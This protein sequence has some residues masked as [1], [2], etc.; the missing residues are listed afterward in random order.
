M[1]TFDG[2]HPMSAGDEVWWVATGAACGD[3]S[4]VGTTGGVLDGTK[5]VSVTLSANMYELCMRQGGSGGTAMKHSHVTAVVVY[6]S[7]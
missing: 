7:P 4:A 5:S 6:R 1:L 2:N 3:G